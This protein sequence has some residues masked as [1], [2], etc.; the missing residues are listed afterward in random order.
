MSL[1]VVLRPEAQQDLTDAETW[2]ERQRSG[3]GQDFLAEVSVKFD[4]IAAQ[5][6]MYA[7]AWK[8]MRAAPLRRFPFVVY[9][10]AWDDRVEVVAILHGSRDPATWQARA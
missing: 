1:P 10:R 5:P 3:L 4:E 8:D 2:Y 9:Y 7:V 6:Q